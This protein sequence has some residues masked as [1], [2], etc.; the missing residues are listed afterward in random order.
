MLGLWFNSR[1]RPFDL[2]VY[3]AE[4]VSETE[5]GLEMPGDRNAPETEMLR[6]RNGSGTEMGLN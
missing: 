2:N 6:N 1:A 4:N 3:L 5:M